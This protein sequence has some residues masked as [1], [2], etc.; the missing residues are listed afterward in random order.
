MARA[1]RICP[2][3]G[4][5]QPAEGRY[6]PAHNKD[7]EKARGSRQKRGY[8]SNH[9]RQRAVAAR[10]VEAGLVNCARCGQRIHPG[11]EWALDH[12]DT[13]RTKYLGPSHKHCNDSAGGKAAHRKP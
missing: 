4:C 9:Y 2:K 3:P 12:D 13:D 11:T 5:P 1:R 6:C 10:Q 8:G 7:Y